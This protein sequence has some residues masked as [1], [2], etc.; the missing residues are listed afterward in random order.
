[1]IQFGLESH[2]NEVGFQQISEI[3]LIPA[4][5]KLI[6]CKF[7]NLAFDISIN[8][9]VGLCKLSFMSQL[10]AKFS[11]NLLLKRSLFLIKSWSYYEAG[12]LGSNVGLMSSY[13]LEI[14]ILYMF[15]NFSHLFNNEIEAVLTFFQVMHETD[16]NKK[17]FT[18]SGSLDIDVYYEKLKNNNYNLNLLIQSLKE[19][20]NE[21]KHIITLDDLILVNKHFEK[22]DDSKSNKK[23]IDAKLVNIIDPLFQTNN[24]GKSLNFH[25][26]SKLTKIFE[27]SA[28]NA[29]KLIKIKQE[30]VLSPLQYFN[31][32]SKI[33]S[34]V[35]TIRN[36]ELFKKYLLIPK[37]LID[38]SIKNHSESQSNLFQDENNIEDDENEEELLS[39]VEIEKIINGENSTYSY[40]FKSSEEI[41]IVEDYLFKQKS[42]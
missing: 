37:I 40:N 38:Y 36:S 23:V 9:F 29:A 39:K 35:I 16:C 26:Y 28:D 21:D 1:M 3:T 42:N 6:K 14:L 15:N 18:I 33:F 8:N 20:N 5:V 31:S 4:E 32:L 25:N 17:I 19:E 2:N 34:K 30:K 12:I 22:F 11:N 13:A 7:D 10:E 27:I 41:S 24:L